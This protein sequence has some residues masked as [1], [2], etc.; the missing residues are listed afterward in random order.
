MLRKAVVITE[1]KLN[2]KEFED[3]LL[4]LMKKVA[5]KPRSVKVQSVMDYVTGNS[6]KEL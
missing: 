6:K 1:T 4:D 3:W 2:Q 5:V